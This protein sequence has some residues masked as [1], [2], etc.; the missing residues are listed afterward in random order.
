MAIHFQYF[1]VSMINV[2]IIDDDKIALSGIKIKLSDSEITVVGEAYDGISGIKLLSKLSP[3]VL[4]LDFHLPDITGLEVYNRIY[5]RR[6]KMKTVF[7]TA[8]SHVPTT[9]RILKAKPSGILIKNSNFSYVEAIKSIMQ[10]K[11]YTE[12][13]LAYK[14]VNYVVEGH[15]VDELSDREHEVAIQFSRGRLI[16]EIAEILDVSEKTIYNHKRE[17]FRKIGTKDI[18]AIREKLWGQGN[19]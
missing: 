19:I 11:P 15:D 6:S 3:D 1:E 17:A 5:N 2:F 12:P 8:S 14:L 10:G 13:T 9:V 16:K 18:P 4:I 7:I